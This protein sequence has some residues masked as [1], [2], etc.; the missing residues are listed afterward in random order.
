MAF[1]FNRKVIYLS[2]VFNPR[3]TG[4]IGALPAHLTHL[5]PINQLTNE[6]INLQAHSGGVKAECET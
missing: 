5:R 3:V 2:S 1:N 6:P 4:A